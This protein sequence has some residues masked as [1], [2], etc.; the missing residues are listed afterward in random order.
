MA[1]IAAALI[2]LPRTGLGAPFPGATIIVAPKQVATTDVRS[3]YKECF[4][5][6]RLRT[7]APIKA[8]ASFYQ[9]EATSN[10]AKLF[11]DTGNKFPDYR[12]LAFSE[13]KFMFVVLDRKS[14]STTVNVSYKVTA[15]CG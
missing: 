7:V 10:G 5:R 1:I 15:N 6:Y 9:T 3:K 13:P 14:E 8:V 11:D 12:T 2:V 4:V